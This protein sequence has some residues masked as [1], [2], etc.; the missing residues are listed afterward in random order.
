MSCFIL[1]IIA[2]KKVLKAYARHWNAAISELK[3]DK[4]LDSQVFSLSTEVPVL[5]S[6]SLVF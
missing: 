6:L 1:Y 5:F 4:F 2:V 3:C